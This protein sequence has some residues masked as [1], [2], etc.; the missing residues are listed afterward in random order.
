MVKDVNQ[1]DFLLADLIER[2]TNFAQRADIIRLE[3]VHRHG[4]L[5]VDIDSTA[6]RSLGE[7][8]FQKKFPDQIIF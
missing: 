2:S 1:E 6:L 5:Y 8:K 7:E 4:G 3:I